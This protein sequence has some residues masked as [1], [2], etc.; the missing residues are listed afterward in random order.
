MSVLLIH[1][2]YKSILYATFMNQ[3]SSSKKKIPMKMLPY[4]LSLSILLLSCE[5]ENEIPA[6]IPGEF[7]EH[8]LDGYFIISV[9]FDTHGNAWIGTFK[10]GLIKYNSNET[11][12]YNS[13]N[14][15]IQDSS[16]IYNIA[17]DREN[18]V[19]I[20][21]EDLI[22][23]DGT[24]FTRYNSSNTP[25]PVDN[26]RSVAID[27]EDNIWFIS[28]RYREGGIVKYDG[29][30]W[31]VYTPDNSDLPA[32]LVH[33][34]AIDKNDNVWLALADKVG[35]TSLVKISG[36]KWTIYDSED[37]GFTPYY[38]GNI[39]TNSQNKLV[40]AI[41]YSLSSSISNNG[42]QV[43]IFDGHSSEKLQYDSI[44]NIKSVM[45]DNHDNIW[46]IGYDSYAV[47]NGTGW[48]INETNFKEVGVFAIEQAPD[49]KIWIGTGDGIYISDIP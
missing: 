41:D 2:I 9:A 27:S 17:I 31:T 23:Y 28:S 11:I 18:N 45:V 3:I 21:S 30:N 8:I 14:S 26:V 5:Q 16:V 24:A 39:R 7:N 47:Y 34:I 40:G 32:N 42:P 19:W 6:E 15:I 25:M 44:S 38:F 43:F 13:K 49:N 20:G 10:Q 4:F 33:S 29:K 35:E 12:V 48:T 36:Q 37:L 46:C 1:K 22:K